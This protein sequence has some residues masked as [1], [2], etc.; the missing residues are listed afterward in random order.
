MVESP[1]LVL[2]FCWSFIFLETWEREREFHIH[3]Q[4]QLIINLSPT[5]LTPTTFVFGFLAASDP[6]KRSQTTTMDV[7]CFSKLI[8]ASVWYCINF[9]FFFWA[10]F[11]YSTVL[12][13]DALFMCFVCERTTTRGVDKY[14]H[15]GTGTTRMSCQ[16]LSILSVQDKPVWFVTVHP[17]AKVI[18]MFVLMICTPSI[19]TSLLA[20]LFLLPERFRFLFRLNFVHS[21]SFCLLSCPIS[22]LRKWKKQ[23]VTEL[24]IFRV[25]QSSNF[26]FSHNLKIGFYLILKGFVWI[27]VQENGDRKQDTE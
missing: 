16:L 18:L 12:L 15:L 23:E 17:L 20:L 5:F 11:D 24:R 4:T 3:P 8:F 9:V 21:G 1:Q 14:R 2:P 25:S 6:R 27:Y 26:L 10:H 13:L 19:C 7:S 22:Y